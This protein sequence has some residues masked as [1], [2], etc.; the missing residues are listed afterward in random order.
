M[1]SKPVFGIEDTHG[2]LQQFKADIRGSSEGLN[3]SSAFASVQR[4]RPYEGK[5]RPIPHGLMV[6]HR[7]GPVD[8]TYTIGGKTFAR[9]VHPG[10]VFFLPGDY[11]CDAN[12][13]GPLD[14]THI[15]LRSDLFCHPETAQNLICGVAPLLGE[16]DAV[17]QHL[18]TAIGDTITGRLPASQLFIEPIA[19]AIAKRLIA[20]NY[21]N[22]TPEVGK[23]SHH[24]LTFRQMQRIREF[25][26]ANLDADIRLETLASL[27]GRSRVYFIRLFKATTG[28][29][30][31]QY[32]L[33]LRVE[34][35]KM[36]LA[37]DTKSIA[38]IA[39]A[40]G[41]THQEH[42]TRIFRRFTGVTP[43]RFRRIR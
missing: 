30:P 2:I 9:Q 25:V 17:L 34:H 23:T 39:F 40:C 3:W 43:A 36:L 37:D 24:R 33:N 42:L 22:S 15:Y 13:I 27:C 28:M 7:D 14:S 26:E 20:I 4:E 32:V 16:P 35:A 31:Y 38:D 5:L 21:N 19:N 1:A 12:L 41:F 11:E 8:I 6:L 29:S 10:G 18:A